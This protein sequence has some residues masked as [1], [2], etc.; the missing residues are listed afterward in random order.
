MSSSM[1]GPTRFLTV[2]LVG[3]DED[4]KFSREE[5]RKVDFF[6]C[7]S[8]RD[9]EAVGLAYESACL[10]A[11]SLSNCDMDGE[12]DTCEVALNIGCFDRSCGRAVMLLSS[13]ER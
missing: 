11:V 9:K 13:C 1:R 5:A 8:R 6:D 10:V 7:W 3:C 4:V 2:N 12:P